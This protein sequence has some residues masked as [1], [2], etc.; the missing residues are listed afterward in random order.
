MCDEQGL[1]EIIIKNEN[2]FK[3]EKIII[4][5]IKLI[6]IIKKMILKHPKSKLISFLLLY[7]LCLECSIF[8]IALFLLDNIFW[9]KTC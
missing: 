6:R 3:Q 2:K 1:L 8:S 5:N 7:L 4:T 9:L